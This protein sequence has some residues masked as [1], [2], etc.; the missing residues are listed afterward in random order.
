[1]PQTLSSQ[2]AYNNMKL[3]ISFFKEMLRPEQGSVPE[4]YQDFDLYLTERSLMP[5]L[6]QGLDALTR[7]VDKQSNNDRQKEGERSVRFNPLTWLAQYLLRNHPRHVKDH[8]S[9]MYR[10]FSELASLERG[11]RVLLRKREEMEEMYILMAQEMDAANLVREDLPILIQN[12]DEQWYLQ[13]VFVNNMPKDFQ[14]LIPAGEEGSTTTNVVTFE[15]FWRWFEVYVQEHDV[16]RAGHFESA[17]QRKLEDEQQAEKAKEEQERHER[18]VQEA[19]VERSKLQEQFE[20]FSADMYLN[21]DITR[22]INKGATIEGVEE[23]ESSIPLQGDHISLILSMVQIWG[24]AMPEDMPQDVWTDGALAVW[25][26][27]LSE[28]GLQG[29]RVDSVSLRKLIDKDA[30]EDYLSIAFAV[31]EPDELLTRCVEVKGFVED[32]IDIV[33][34]A[35]DEDTGEVAHFVLPEHQVE[36]VRKRLEDTSGGPVMAQVDSVTGR[37]TSIVPLMGR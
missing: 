31:N 25:R 34:E 3:D 28:R 18:A 35:I 11:R 22:I 23:R 24:V 32:D 21:D 27:W 4:E 30:F 26:R 10:E 1:M 15:D 16:I 19:L 8:R 33:V 14:D 36:E 6:L 17:A 20:M 9:P 2:E 7:H 13:G 12:L 37:V 29:Q 5:L